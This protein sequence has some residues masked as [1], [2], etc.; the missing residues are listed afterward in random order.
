MQ[1]CRGDVQEFPQKLG[2]IPPV[3]LRMFKAGVCC[4]A[5]QLFK[6]TEKRRE[7]LDYE[8]IDDCPFVAIPPITENSEDLT[9]LC[10][11]A[12]NHP[13]IPKPRQSN[14]EVFV[15][16]EDTKKSENAKKAT[17]PPPPPLHCYK[18]DEEIE[19][20]IEKSPVFSLALLGG[21]LWDT[22]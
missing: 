2:S 1:N 21:Q 19:K 3:I 10:S 22:T 17:K 13:V 11:T 12:F 20:E 16:K 14:D 9:A 8:F 7:Q 6:D 5:M 4:E 18:K 15:Q